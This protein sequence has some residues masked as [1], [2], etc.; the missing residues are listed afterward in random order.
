MSIVKKIKMNP[1]KLEQVFFDIVKNFFTRFISALF[2]FKKR[3]G[4]VLAG[5]TTFFTVLS[6][7]P[8]MLLLIS[9]IGAYIGDNDVAKNHVMETLFA[10]FPKVDPWILKSLKLLVEEQ[11]SSHSIKPYQV[12]LWFF[13]CLG[14][15]TSFV[16]GINILSKVDPDGGFFQ[17]D[18]RSLFFGVLMALFFLIVFMMFEKQFV[19]TL[20]ETF[21]TDSETILSIIE[22]LVWPFSIIFFGLF[23]KFSAQIKVSTKDAMLG[24]FV[25]TCCF[26]LGKS[27]YWIYLKYFKDDLYADYGNFYNFMVGMIWIYFLVCSFYFGAS[28]TYVSKVKVFGRGKKK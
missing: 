14:I 28:F 8:A 13:T 25:F 1:E 2:L 9:V 17:D 22:V 11:I 19:L 15:S 27:S 24:G 4:E 18:I 12:G 7:G 23:Y 26:L 6:F 3:K 10:S 21:L 5:A 16:F 20:V